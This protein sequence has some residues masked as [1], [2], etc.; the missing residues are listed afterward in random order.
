ML[1][2]R[3]ITLRDS[4]RG[5]LVVFHR[6]SGGSLKVGAHISVP[7]GYEAIVTHYDKICDRLT[8]GNYKFDRVDMPLLT[9]LNKPKNTRKGEVVPKKIKADLYFVL[10]DIYKDLQYKATAKCLF[11]N[12]KKYVKIKAS[13][14]VRVVNAL[15][16][17]TVLLNDYSTISGAAAT[18][19]LSVYVSA[20]ADKVLSSNVFP[21]EDYIN[22]LSKVESLLDGYLSKP[23]GEIGVE[24]SG[25]RIQGTFVPNK[26]LAKLEENKT[27]L[28]ENKE[29]QDFID[30]KIKTQENVS[31]PEGYDIN[32]S[33]IF[34]P[35]PPI[36][37]PQRDKPESTREDIYNRYLDEIKQREQKA[38]PPVEEAP[39]Q[40][41][42]T[43]LSDMPERIESVVVAPTPSLAQEVSEEKII[44]SNCGT[45]LPKNAKF[46]YNCGV[47]TSTYKTCPCC[48]AKNFAGDTKCCVCKSD[49]N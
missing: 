20:S 41:P 25:N 1:F 32:M 49:L 39:L 36:V 17:L 35:T 42:P 15:K 45:I 19:E 4:E 6:L 34:T 12:K 44:C 18:K 33:D 29:L 10:T 26:I 3:T 38:E 48:G 23:L 30:K 14:D 46:C 22:N 5:R 9:K 7:E 47:T 8:P 24:S 31:A 27:Q 21:V 13:C 37:T 40:A 28:D 11:D 43:L 16:F 2:N